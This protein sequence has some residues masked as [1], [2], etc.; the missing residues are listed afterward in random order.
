MRLVLLV[1]LLAA[2]PASAQS[3]LYSSCMTSAEGDGALPP[4]VAEA[5]CA[6]LETRA[7][8]AGETAASIDRYLAFAEGLDADP[9]GVDVAEDPPGWA[10]ETSS[11][12]REGMAACV[13]DVQQRAYAESHDPDVPA[14]VSTGAPGA[15]VAAPAPPRPAPPAGLRTGDGTAPVQTQQTGKGAA[16]RIVG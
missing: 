3:R 2:G 14:V 11:A 5:L 6:C 8:A 7:L 9:S 15:G 10:T 4:G 16:V 13:L 12:L 1:L